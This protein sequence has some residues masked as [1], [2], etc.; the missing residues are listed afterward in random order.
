L[1][2]PICV[3]LW[4]FGGPTGALVVV[5]VGEDSVWCIHYLFPCSVAFGTAELADGPRC[6]SRTRY[7]HHSG[8]HPQRDFDTGSPLSTVSLIQV[9]F[10]AGSPWRQV[11]LQVWVSNP[12]DLDLLSYVW[13]QT[14]L[15]GSRTGL[16]V[17]LL[18]LV[19]RGRPRARRSISCYGPD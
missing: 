8:L 4:L 18:C 11:L 6:F 17:F 14:V 15:T 3:D 10:L 16:A 1:Q 9:S 2:C 19:I 5:S 7:S 13:S 12:R